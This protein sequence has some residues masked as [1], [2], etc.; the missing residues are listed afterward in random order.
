M[1]QLIE[2]CSTQFWTKHSI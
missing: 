2:G 1:T